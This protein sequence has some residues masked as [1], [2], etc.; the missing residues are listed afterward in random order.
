MAFSYSAMVDPSFSSFV[1]EEKSEYFCLTERHIQAIWL[2]QKYIKNLVT[3]EGEKVKVI[4]P[5]IWNA[6]AGPDFLKA[7]LVIGGKEVH[8]DI[9][10]DLCEEYWNTHNHS[11]DER[12]R[13]TILH[14]VYWNSKAQ[15][16]TTTLAGK[17]IPT[18]FLEDRLTISQKRIGRLID[19][20][21]YPYKKFVGTGRCSK[22]L[23]H[24]C[25]EDK[26]AQLLR[27]A[28]LWRLG[29]KRQYLSEW[30][31]STPLQP[32][33]GI[34]MALGYKQNT[35]V[36][37]E[38]FLWL[39]SY[40]DRPQREILSAAMGACGYFEEA[41]MSRW[42]PSDE[43]NNLYRLWQS[44][45]AEAEHQ[46][47][48]VLNQIRPLNSPLRRLAYLS[49]LMSDPHSEKILEKLKTLWSSFLPSLGERKGMQ[50]LYQ[51]LL[52]LIPE[53]NDAH[54]NSHYNFEEEPRKEFLSLIGESTKKQVLINTFLP[55]I[56]QVVL[57]RFD[58]GEMA[59]FQNFYRSLASSKSGKSRYL[60]HRFFG[61]DTR[62]RLKQADL[63]QGALQ[64]HRDFC[65][66]YEASCEGCPFVERYFAK[67]A[68]TFETYFAS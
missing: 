2:E 25:G 24:K 29:Q 38:L 32:L 53:Y 20:D 10:I 55:L 27:T 33:G 47:K 8:G 65:I 18:V 15:F 61:E 28:A 16:S 52:S 12:H 34:A 11:R 54:W 17:A 4:S 13:N 3:K 14:I 7:H 48:L 39:L 63:E 41:Y 31:P 44:M 50:R 66:Y 30:V 59:A 64:I 46:C 9:E 67:T 62:D 57:Q 36:F 26:S 37:L 5:G 19:L 43:Y 58:M 56:Y 49:F 35:Q 60:Q 22:L 1:A 42:Q 23:F 40:R 21:L 6:E 51:S 68:S 45:A